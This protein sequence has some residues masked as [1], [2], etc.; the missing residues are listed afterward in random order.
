MNNTFFTR[1]IVL[2]MLIALVLAFGVQSVADAAL[3]AR[4]ISG[5]LE[6]KPLVTNQTFEFSFSISGVPGSRPDVG[7][8]PDEN[9]ESITITPAGGRIVE[10]RMGSRTYSSLNIEAGNSF[11]LEEWHTDSGNGSTAGDDEALTTGTEGDLTSGTVYVK[12]E[13]RTT[14]AAELTVGEKTITVVDAETDG[15]TTDTAFTSLVFTAY[16]V[17]LPG[18][19][20]SLRFAATTTTPE[21]NPTTKTVYPPFDP[22]D[23]LYDELVSVTVAD[24]ATTTN[25]SWALVDFEVVEGDGFVYQDLNGDSQPDT[26]ADRNT[27]TTTTLTNGDSVAMVRLRLNGGTNKIRAQIKN[28]DH[29]Y[30]VTYLFQGTGTTPTPGQPPPGASLTVS[31]PTSGTVGQTITVTASTSDRSGDREVTFTSNRGGTFSPAS[32]SV[33]TANNGVATIRFTLPST[34]G[35]VTINAS[36]TGYTTLPAMVDVTSGLGSLTVSTPRPFSGNAGETVNIVVGTGTAGVSITLSGVGFTSATGTTVA[37]GF[38]TIPIV[39]P[40]TA[41]N[42]QLYANANGYERELIVVIVSGT[43]P[44]N[45]PVRL[46]IPS[47]T[48]PAQTVTI[49]SNATLRVL[50]TNT[51]TNQPQSGVAVTFRNS[52]GN[53][54]ATV[55]T[56]TNGEATHQLTVS[57]LQPQVISAVITDTNVDTSGTTPVTFTITGRAQQPTESTRLSIIRPVDGSGQ[58]VISGGPGA[59]YPLT[60]L[61]NNENNTPAVNQVVTLT[62][63]NAA[64]VVQS[65]T[66]LITDNTGRATTPDTF[67]LPIAAGQY[68]ITAVSGTQTRSVTVTVVAVRLVKNTSNS[69]SGDNQEGDRGEVLDD[70]FVVKVVQDIT[71]TE[72]PVQGVAVTFTVVDGNGE[73]SAASNAT[74]GDS[75]LVVRSDTNGDVRAYLV[76]DEDDEDNRVR[77]SLG[78]TNVADVFFDATGAVVPDDIEIVSGDNQRVIPNR[79]TD[80]MVV[81]V[82]DE[83]GADLQGAT[84]TFSLRGGSG[85]LTPRSATTDRNGEAEAELLP[86]EAGTYFVTASVQGVPSVRFTIN[87]GDLADSI[88]IV[89]GNNQRGTPGT[90]LDDPFV[91]EVLDDDDDV[92]SGVTVTFSVTAGGGSLSATSVTTNSRGRAQTTLTLGDDLGRNTVRA[93]VSGVSTTVTFTATAGPTEPDV[94]LPATQRAHTYWV[95]TDS[96]TLHR[97][98]GSSVENIASGVQNVVSLAVTNNRLY[99]VEKTSGNSGRIRRSDL[100]GSNVQLVRDLTAAPAGIAVDTNNSK[101]YL[102]NGFGKVQSINF[103]GSGYEP[104]LI[105]GLNN[106]KDIAVGSGR[107]YWI[108]GDNTV[109]SAN[110]DGSGVTRIATGY[111][112][113]T[114][115]SIAVGGGKV[116]WTEETNDSAGYIHSANLDGSNVQELASLLA[117]PE[118]ISVDTTANKLYFTNSR[119]RIM[120]SDLSGGSIKIVVADLTAP[121]DISVPS[122]TTRPPG[123]FSRYD[124]NRDGVVNNTDAALVADALGESPPS[125]PRLDVNG[126]GS[127]N[128]L[129]LLLV[130]DNRE[131]VNAAPTVAVAKLPKVSREEIQKQINLL[132]AT[133]NHSLTAQHT[134]AY[135]QRLLEVVTPE[136]TRLL[137]NYPNPFNPETWIPYQLATD[138]NVQITIY[139]A[140]GSMV[141]TL[142][143]GHQAEG[144]YTDRSRAAYWDGRNAIGERVASGV[145]F[146]T[147]TTDTFSATRKMLILK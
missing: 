117:A 72:T 36:A 80:P 109:H 84:V 129:D 55:N 126:D 105:T 143:L 122:G 107:V 47:G 61:F 53:D 58:M 136:K 3:T 20:Q 124:V 92:V 83:D 70:P 87:V 141:R 119:G 44:T 88:E 62:V 120:Q 99:W 41:G 38:A 27:Q 22:S 74:S 16:A 59:T 57:Q 28:T 111:R 14:A 60:I 138:S 97:L 23:P 66:V 2:G 40:T 68:T 142:M 25:S 101:I 145:Y 106:P 52:S 51:N 121:G 147:L 90:V 49:G 19:V 108:T 135:L 140:A 132:I 8:S 17:R 35:Q 146:Y 125:N 82:T 139:D 5:D 96:G 89:S 133:D 76:L 39:L 115:H 104:D 91:V 18:D 78:I 7:G 56:G 15:D 12:V 10:V 85:T 67:R 26:P 43:A 63:R 31:A 13:P 144:Y 9:R 131:N 118:G 128:F 24:V 102:T 71:T 50:V 86:R 37:S 6:V 94:R 65:T 137:A 98:V 32:G 45:V 127:V 112:Y 75:S 29:T 81:R 123:T 48:N 64:Q 103:N 30:T 95:N 110:V 34:T 42:Y 77:A 79:Y 54:L 4:K 130:F 100:N 93:S 33:Q 1:K 46:T 73:L 69:I 21:V 11:T 116:F 113:D 114:L 134:L